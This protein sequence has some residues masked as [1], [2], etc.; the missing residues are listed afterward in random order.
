MAR[1]VVGNPFEN[2][3]PTVSP[4]ASPVDIYERGVVKNSPFAALA[5]TLKSL[6]AKAVPAM[7]REEQRRA[8]KEYAEG[9]KLWGETRINIGDAVR[10]G[11][12]KEGESPYLRKGYRAAN[13]HVLAA[14]YATEL[15]HQLETKKLYHDGDPEKI[16]KFITDFQTSYQSNNNFDDF[17]VVETAEI[18]GSN[19]MKANVAF[20]ASWREKHTEYMT[21][22]VYEGF[23]DKIATY[24]FGIVDP[25]LSFEARTK[26]AAGLLQFIQQEVKQAEQDGMDRK[27]V[28]NMVAD[29]LRLTALQNNSYKPLEL[30]SQIKVGTGFLSGTYENQLKNFE[31]R[32]AIAKT[33]EAKEEAMVEAN[34]AITDTNR[35]TFSNTASKELAN[36]KSEDRGVRQNAKNVIMQQISL[37]YEMN[38]DVS[39]ARAESLQKLVDTFEKRF[40]EVSVQDERLYAEA[41]IA[42]QNEPDPTQ[43]NLLIAKALEDGAFTTEGHINKALTLS[44]QAIGTPVY[45]LLNDNTGP[46]MMSFNNYADKYLQAQAVFSQFTKQKER[47]RISRVVGI[48]KSELHLALGQFIQKYRGENEGQDPNEQALYEQTELLMPVLI[49]RY[50]PAELEATQKIVTEARTPPPTEV[51]TT[52]RTIDIP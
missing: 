9:Q 52:S 13:L 16:E 15:K 42:I 24:T 20:K 18:F 50:A 21:E 44:G 47:Q 14:N 51:D 36:L 45:R 31:T 48:V 41:L 38:D 32:A 4:T 43:R 28:G 40:E 27:K 2:Q 30:M 1:S 35:Q 23:R 49:R 6:E 12:I 34:E 39:T 22:K 29:A 7:Q 10:Q 33:I 26:K 8:E 17:G 11:I 46:V 3:I 37:L 5:N 19:A 25:S